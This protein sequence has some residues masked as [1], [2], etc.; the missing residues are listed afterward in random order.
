MDNSAAYP[1]LAQRMSAFLIDW[2]ILVFFYISAAILTDGL[3]PKYAIARTIIMLAVIAS[4]D[5]I[6]NSVACTLGQLAMGIRVRRYRDRS[7]HINLFQGY[8]R[9]LFKLILGWYSFLTL[10]RTKERRAVHDMVSSSIM[11]NRKYVDA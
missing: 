9:L 8:F 2:A 5:P 10:T 4:Y 1:S 7:R 3:D 6:L 11:L